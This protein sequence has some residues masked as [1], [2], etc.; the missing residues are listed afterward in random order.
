MKNEK[1]YSIRCLQATWVL[2]GGY[3]DDLSKTI[4]VKKNTINGWVANE[5][6]PAVYI[7]DL[8]KASNN[9]FTAEDFLGKHDNDK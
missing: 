2:C 7:L 9:R 3:V 4:N 6:I 8:V 5:R 1:P